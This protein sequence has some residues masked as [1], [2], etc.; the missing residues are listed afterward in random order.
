MRTFTDKVRNE[1]IIFL[2]EPSG[3]LVEI[4]VRGSVGMDWSTGYGHT[5]VRMGNSGNR[6]SRVLTI[7]VF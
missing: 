5:G 2:G 3:V 4:E 1:G 7:I 6:T